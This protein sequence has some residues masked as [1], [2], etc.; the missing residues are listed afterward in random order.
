MTLAL[1]TPHRGGLPETIARRNADGWRLSGRKIYSTGALALR[2]FSVYARTDEDVPRV[3]YFL[4]PAASRGIRIEETWDHLG[5][6][7]TRSDD[8]V[9]EDVAIPSH[10]AV[11]VRTP[12]EWRSAPQPAWSALLVASIYLGVADAARDWLV[13]F[14][15]GRVPANLGKPLVCDNGNRVTPVIKQLASKFATAPRTD[16]DKTQTGQQINR[17]AGLL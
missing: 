1:G 3:G 13:A 4:V 7:A 14:L 8:V 5:M 10:Y 17:L 6:R 2:W 16:L 12:N 9:F 15:R 11:D